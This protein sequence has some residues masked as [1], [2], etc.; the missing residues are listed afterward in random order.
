MWIETWP[1]LIMKM[2]DMPYYHYKGSKDKPKGKQEKEKPEPLPGTTDI[3][4]TK[5]S[6]Y[7]EP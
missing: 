6:K 1:N 7:I 4:K 5:F 3:L 2:R